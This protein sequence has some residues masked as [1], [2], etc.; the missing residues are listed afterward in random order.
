V[1]SPRL[2]DKFSVNILILGLHIIQCQEYK[3]IEGWFANYV[4]IAYEEARWKWG[5]EGHVVAVPDTLYAKFAHFSLGVL[6]M[7]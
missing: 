6:D 4:S 1:K 5:R 2:V 3:L 7:A